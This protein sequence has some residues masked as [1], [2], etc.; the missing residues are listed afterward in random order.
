M[1]ALTF[2]TRIVLYRPRFLHIAA[3]RIDIYCPTMD[4]TYTLNLLRSKTLIAAALRKHSDE[5]QTLKNSTKTTLQD[6]LKSAKGIQL[7]CHAPNEYKIGMQLFNCHPP[8][9]QAEEMRSGELALYHTRQRATTI[10]SG[11]QC[12]SSAVNNPM[13]LLECLRDELGQK[14]MRETLEVNSHKQPSEEAGVSFPIAGD[15]IDANEESRELIEESTVGKK[16]RTVNI[17]F[18]LSDSEESSSED[19]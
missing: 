8:A 19:E 1:S 9:P 10:K 18:G 14:R 15:E 12:C 13:V 11:F 5:L 17:S 7:N 3:K 4:G 16:A 6:L 2:F